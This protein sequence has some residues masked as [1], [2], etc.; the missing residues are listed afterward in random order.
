MKI[1]ILTR[2]DDFGTPRRMIEG[3]FKTRENAEKERQNIL[4]M[5][6]APSKL[7]IDTE[8]EEKELVD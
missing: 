8:I 7:C 4:K 3:V 6:G 1:Y 5:Y 2:T